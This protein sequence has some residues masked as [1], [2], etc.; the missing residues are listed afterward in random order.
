MATLRDENSQLVYQ[1]QRLLSQLENSHKTLAN[2]KVGVAR[3]RGML[4]LLAF[5]HSITL[6]L[7]LGQA[8]RR[9]RS[10]RRVVEEEEAAEFNIRSR[11]ARDTPP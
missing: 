7:V 9:K 5:A 1:S 6:R 8:M 3:G 4:L 2:S 11:M 10:R